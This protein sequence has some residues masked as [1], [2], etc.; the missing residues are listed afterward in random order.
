MDLPDSF[1]NLRQLASRKFHSPSLTGAEEKLLSAA[2]IGEIA[3]LGPSKDKFDKTNDPAHAATWQDRTIRADLIRWLCIDSEAGKYLSPTGVGLGGACVDGTLDLSRVLIRYPLALTS[4]S[5]SGGLLLTMAETRSLNLEC[6]HIGPINAREVVIGGAM[7]LRF[8]RVI[9]GVD[10]IDASLRSYL[11]CSGARFANPGRAA[12]DANSATFG[13]GVYLNSWGNRGPFRAYGEV[14]LLNAQIGGPLDCNGGYFLHRRH[15]SIRASSTTIKGGVSLGFGFRANGRVEL[16]GADIGGE[17]NCTAGYILASAKKVQPRLVALSMDRVKI[18]GAALFS[19]SNETTRVRVSCIRGK[20]SL[21]GA[22]IGGALTCLGTRFINPN[23]P[24]FDASNVIIGGNA[25]LAAFT[26]VDKKIH[27]FHAEGEVNLIDARIESYLNCDGGQFLNAGKTA[28]TANSAKVGGNVMLKSGFN[29]NGLVDL[30]A[31]ELAGTL[32][33]REATFNNPNSTALSANAI[34]VGGNVFL[35]A[36]FAGQGLV[37]LSFAIIRENVS[38]A[39]GSFV[40]PDK[41]ALAAFCA[42][43][44][45][46]AFLGVH[47]EQ[48]IKTAKVFRAEGQVNLNNMRIGGSL[49]LRGGNFHQSTVTVLNGEIGI[50]LDASEAQFDCAAVN[51]LNAERVN[52]GGVLFW[53]QLRLGAKTILNLL[54]ARVGVLADD[55]ASWPNASDLNVNGFVYGAISPQSPRDIT[56]IEWLARQDAGYRPQPYKQLAKVLR[57][58]GHEADATIIEVQRERERRAS[59]AKGIVEIGQRR[60]ERRRVGTAF[61]LARAKALNAWSLI[62]YATI[63]YGYKPWRLSYYAMGAL[64][65]GWIMFASGYQLSIMSPTTREA[66]IDFNTKCER[67]AYYPRFNA[68]VYS[69]ETLVP[70]LDLRQKAFWLPTSAVALGCHTSL[71]IPGTAYDFANIFGFVLRGYFWTHIIIGWLLTALLTVALTGLVRRE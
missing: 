33:C 48:G 46:S 63:G 32:E 49:D 11:T 60:A 24:A 26:D 10:L 15:V 17:F 13:G 44:G 7:L 6:S 20:T 12:L 34:R 58:A 38:C 18:G 67:P 52:I 37:D 50:D 28:L 69:L 1:E 30:T 36:G 39:G 25:T 53:R 68:F 66:T 31:A 9:G 54:H 5:I 29:A 27:P 40:N 51:G 45:G 19:A 3:W 14:V 64:F 22:R 70:V 41:I 55:A 65:I 21:V 42:S 4:C 71:M 56:R 8:S 35:N 2:V 16:T 43:I 57:E 61:Y 47:L 23:E 59:L 62:L